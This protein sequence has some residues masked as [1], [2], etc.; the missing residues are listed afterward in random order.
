MKKLF[1]NKL[2]CLLKSHF[3]IALFGIVFMSYFLSCEMESKKKVLQQEIDISEIMTDE[4]VD[5]YLQVNQNPTNETLDPT[6]IIENQKK[7]VF[8]VIR[9]EEPELKD[10]YS[11]F[12]TRIW[13][14][15]IICSKIFEFNEFNE[16]LGYKLMDDVQNS[17]EFKYRIDAVNHNFYNDVQRFVNYDFRDIYLNDKVKVKSIEYLEF[18]SYKEAS[19]KRNEIMDIEINMR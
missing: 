8:V 1:P 3:S 18:D 9:T 14:D 17:F 10:K 12:P 6:I 4:E 2:L 11:S 7:F 19:I 16:D 15:Y 5:D 13:N